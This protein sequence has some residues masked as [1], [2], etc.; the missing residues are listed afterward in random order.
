M[1]Q[2]ITLI[3]F[4]LALLLAA[5]VTACGTDSSSSGGSSGSGGDG[6]SLRV[7]DAPFTDV[8]LLHITFRE[9]HLRKAD[10]GWI[11][12][13]TG[14]LV[15]TTI[16]IAGLQ[17]TKTADLL[18]NVDVP[19]GDYTELRLI[20][21]DPAWIE[22]TGGGTEPLEIPGGTSAGLKIKGDFMVVEGK[23]T[24]LV[25]DFDLLRSIG[26][27]GGPTPKYTM[28]P[29]LRLIKG[30]AFGHARGTVPGSMLT[31]TGCSTAPDFV[32]NAVYIF[33]GHDVE[34]NDITNRNND[35]DPFTTSRITMDSGGVFMYEAAF[36]P[37]GEYTIAFTC[38]ADKEDLKNDDDLSFFGEM[39][40]TI[41]VNDTLFL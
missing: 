27:T 32:R 15:N 21:D 16:E 4:S 5:S 30:N 36:L 2:I 17:G 7:T 11:F 41:K 40:I 14:E 33:E 37:A 9:V 8:A 24:V 28:K 10:G 38:N 39:N 35:V 12:I 20:V 3:R 26:V 29:V 18:E 13:P 25:I 34:P 6:F 19:E 22:L 31:G 23:P 1:R